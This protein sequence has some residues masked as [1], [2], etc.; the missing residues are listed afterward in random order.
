MSA[1]VPQLGT[2]LKAFDLALKVVSPTWAPPKRAPLPHKRTL[3]H[4]GQFAGTCLE[5]L[6][7]Q[8]EMPTLELVREIVTQLSLK[9]V[10]K[11]AAGLRV[12]RGY[13]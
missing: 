12:Q 1:A 8:G 5:L 10:D 2:E 3:P 9:F 11:A 6:R 4:R 7:K 13:G